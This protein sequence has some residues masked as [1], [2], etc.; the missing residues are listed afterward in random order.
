MSEKYC[1]MTQETIAEDSRTNMVGI[2]QD[3][4]NALLEEGNDLVERFDSPILALKPYDMAIAMYVIASGICNPSHELVFDMNHIS[5]IEDDHPELSHRVIPGAHSVYE[6]ISPFLE[7][8]KSDD[9]FM[10]PATLW[11]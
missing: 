3:T 7:G 1:K 10:W 11:V 5:F 9:G 2:I 8:H 4:I 6:Y